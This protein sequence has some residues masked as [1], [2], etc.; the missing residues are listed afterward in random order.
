MMLTHLIVWLH[1]LAK[2]NQVV[3]ASLCMGTGLQ[4]LGDFEDFL[5]FLW[6]VRIQIVQ[7]ELDFFGGE[8]Q[9]SAH[10]ARSS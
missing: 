6:G 8:V 2:L 4:H 1:V 9:V 3:V 10:C 7:H 5:G